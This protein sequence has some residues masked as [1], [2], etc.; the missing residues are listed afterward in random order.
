MTL[1]SRQ[2]DFGLLGQPWKQSHFLNPSSILWRHLL[3]LL[4]HQARPIATSD[5]GSGALDESST[6][7]RYWPSSQGLC[8][9]RMISAD[10]AQ[11][12]ES[13]DVI[14]QASILSGGLDDLCRRWR[15]VY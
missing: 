9:S 12:M 5:L 6:A 14:E 2:L 15:A 4:L 3:L 7:S 1:E 13:V 8:Y 11:V 10:Q